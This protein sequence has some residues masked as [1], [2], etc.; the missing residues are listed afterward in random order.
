LFEARR[1]ARARRDYAEADRLRVE[2]E[3]LGCKLQDGADGVRLIP[4]VR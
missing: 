3:R 1:V 4:K 2:I